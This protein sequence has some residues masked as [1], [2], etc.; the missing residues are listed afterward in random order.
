MMPLLN[1]LDGSARRNNKCDD[2]W[3]P[4]FHRKKKH[5]HTN[6]LKIMYI[7]ESERYVVIHV[8]GPDNHIAFGR[9]LFSVSLTYDATQSTLRHS[10]TK[11]PTHFYFWNN[12]W[13]CA[14]C[15]GIATQRIDERHSIK[16]SWWKCIIGKMCTMSSKHVVLQ[17]APHVIIN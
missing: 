17:K 16:Y 14:C 7:R 15:L 11:R 12:S 10:I 6:H 13:R 9:W 1:D 8:N 4:F 5:T 2:I 3:A